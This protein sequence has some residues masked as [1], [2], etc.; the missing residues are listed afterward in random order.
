MTAGS[1]ILKKYLKVAETQ[2]ATNAPPTA[3]GYNRPITDYDARDADG[4]AFVIHT[5][6]DHVPPEVAE[7]SRTIARA[8]AEPTAGRFLEK[9]PDYTAGG[10]SDTDVEDSDFEPGPEPEEE[11]EPEDEEEDE[12]PPSQIALLYG[13]AMLQLAREDTCF[14]G[15]S[16]ELALRL[17]AALAIADSPANT[18]QVF[19]SYRVWATDTQ[20]TSPRDVTATEAREYAV[21]R[22]LEA[23]APKGV[24]G[25]IIN[26]NAKIPTIPAGERVWVALNGSCCGIGGYNY[27]THGPAAL[28]EAPGLG[29]KLAALVFLR[30]TPDGLVGS[31]W[32]AA[33]L[34][35]G[36]DLRLRGLPTQPI[37]AALE[38]S[39]TPSDFTK[40]LFAKNLSAPERVFDPYAF[41]AFE[42]PVCLSV[43]LINS[44]GSVVA[45]WLC[46]VGFPADFRG[47]LGDIQKDGTDFGISWAPLTW[48]AFW[49]LFGPPLHLLAPVRFGELAPADKICR[50]YPEA[51]HEA[52]APKL[53]RGSEA[54]WHKALE[55]FGDTAP[56]DWF[57]AERKPPR[58]TIK[59]IAVE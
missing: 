41:L 39:K 34:R 50:L 35:L 2:A 1:S 21:K 7:R 5:I 22:I 6:P 31:Y 54:D 56:T 57:G 17:I 46:G 42:S 33:D 13:D 40:R 49:L 11:D 20:G 8:G 16:G 18:R 58:R 44:D 15:T 38:G 43:S 59:S 23:A 12:E 10:A 53:D 19:V 52:E 14:S 36:S 24:S 32:P 3:V 4:F 25:C 51:P 27:A 28:L 45:N 55:L 9:R 37:A 30:Q 48:R 29:S 26:K 47:F